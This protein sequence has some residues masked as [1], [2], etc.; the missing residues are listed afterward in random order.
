MT[1]TLILPS[2]AS[3]APRRLEIPAFVRRLGDPPPKPPQAV[4]VTIH[5]QPVGFAAG[6][7]SEILNLWP[8]IRTAPPVTLAHDLA[9]SGLLRHC[10]FL[11]AEPGGPLVFRRIAD[12]TVRAL[13]RDWAMQQLGKPNDDDPYSEYAVQLAAHY[14]EAIKGGE[15]VYNHCVIHG[16][17]RPVVYSHLLV[18]WTSPSGQKALLTV[19]DWP[20]A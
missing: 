6:P 3:L 10:G 9:N 18:G 11:N 13:G 2:A 1:A 20:G 5:R 17:A 4:T 14:E 15:P 7:Q 19:I 8:S 16:L 12:A